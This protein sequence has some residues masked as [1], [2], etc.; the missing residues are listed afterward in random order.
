M[1]GRTLGHYRIVEQIGEGGMGKVFR[2]RDDRLQ[3]DVAVKIINPTA[4]GDPD[5]LRRFEQEARAAAALNHPNILAIYDIG[6]DG[7]SPYIVSELLQGRTLRQALFEGALPVRTAVDYARQIA[8]ALVAAHEKNIVHRDLKPENLFITKE[9]LVKILDFGIAKLIPRQDLHGEMAASV[10]ETVTRVGMVMGTASYMSP[11]QLRAKPV[12][13]RT[14]IF[15]FGSILY[16]MLTGLRAFRG[17]TDVDTITAVLKEEPRDLSSVQPNV[18]PAFAPVVM[19]CLEKDPDN[20]FQSAR[21]LIFALDTA[22]RADTRQLPIAERR[23]QIITAKRLGVL[24]AAVLLAAGVWML[25]RAIQQPAPKFTRLTFELGTIYSARF[26]PDGRDVMYDASW[27]GHPARLYTSAAHT[28]QE[29][30]LHFEDS[31]LLSLSP[32]GELALALH[33][34]N[35]S[36][37]EFTDGTLARSPLAGGAPRELMEDVRGADWDAK[38]ALAVIHYAKDRYRLEYPLGNVVYD[39]GG[40]ISHVRVNAVNGSVAFIDHPRMYDDRGSIAV[41]DTGKRRAISP[42]YDSAA[43]LAWSPDGKEVWFTAVEKGYS[44]RLLSASLSGKVRT[45]LS[46]PGGLTLQDIAADGRVLLTMDDE[47]YSMETSTR[48]GKN[49]Q[50]LSWYNWTLPR[51]I[52]PDGQWLLFE[53]SSEPAGEDYAACI[54]KFD[55]SPPIRLSDGT[56]ASFTRDGKFA[57]VTLAKPALH[58]ELVPLGA[59]QGQNVPLPGLESVNVGFVALLPE[60]KRIVVAGNQAGQHSRVF[61]Q[62]LDGS[63]LRPITP[64]GVLARMASPDGKYV[65]AL[66]LDGFAA[67]YPIDGGEPKPIPGIE[68]GWLP[69]QWSADS[70]QVYAYKVRELPASVFSVNVSTGKRELIREISPANSAGALWVTP[71]IMDQQANRFVYGYYQR[72]STLYVVSGLK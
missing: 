35:G 72:F 38:G 24:A 65:A 58:V 4:E 29:E 62:N 32:T 37:F 1:I 20:R 71:I 7:G 56:P 25:A 28:P 19:H 21:D 8:Q 51:D 67:L 69:N 12:D 11:E 5:R 26:T 6:T 55:G 17:E 47:R 48:D 15:S 18:P 30:A 2:A 23:S 68:K 42:E 61:V 53:D 33:A 54:R 31:H 34:R 43:G 57:L 46:V 14:D 70:T 49:V 60:G 3:R 45:R 63:A 64:E 59:G 10:Q 44:R 13:H 27:N 9:G 41:I 50:N 16:E 66:G 36:R 39:T 40:W 52:S 22:L